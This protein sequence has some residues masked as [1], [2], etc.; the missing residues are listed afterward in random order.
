M[1]YYCRH[2]INPNINSM[3]IEVSNLHDIEELP[4]YAQ[5]LRMVSTQEAVNVLLSS[6]LSDSQI[7][8]RVPFNV[9]VNALFV[10]DLN[11]LSLRMI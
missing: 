9:V 6:E 2:R 1:C 3:A 7:C 5:P 10:V 4:V 8:T 11:Q